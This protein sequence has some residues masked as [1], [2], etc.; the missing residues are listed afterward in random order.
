MLLLPIIFIIV[1]GVAGHFVFRKME[2]AGRTKY[3]VTLL[4]SAS[5]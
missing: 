2:I 1:V 5:V 3:L 4:E